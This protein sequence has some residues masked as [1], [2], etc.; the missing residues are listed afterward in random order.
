[1]RIHSVKTHRE[2]YMCFPIY[3]ISHYRYHESRTTTTTAAIN[4]KYINRIPD[5][6]TSF[7]FVIF[8]ILSTR[9]TIEPCNANLNSKIVN[10]RLKHKSTRFHVPI[11]LLIIK[12]LFIIFCSPRV[13]QRFFSKFVN[14]FQFVFFF[15]VSVFS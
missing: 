6:S 11:R 14:V 4:M 3:Q 1:M 5:R 15:K 12:F 2:K 7:N 8:F 10:S 9:K 13:F